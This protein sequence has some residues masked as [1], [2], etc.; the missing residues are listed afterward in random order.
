MAKSPLTV[1]KDKFGDKAKLVEAVK[2]FTTDDL[3]VARINT[4]KGLEHV[5]NAKLLRLHAT[6]TTVKEKFGTR[7][8]LIDAILDAEKRAKDDG[9]KTRLTAFPVPRLYD[10]YLSVTKR[11]KKKPAAEPAPAK[12]AE[13]PAAKKA[14]KAEK[15]AKPAKAAKAP[16]KKG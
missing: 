4:D 9:Y 11:N 5:S 10:Q 12:K 7:A 8:K 6:F 2:A 13:K 16:A 14:E 3:W 1:V 15:S